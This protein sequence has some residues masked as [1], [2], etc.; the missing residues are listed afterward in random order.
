MHAQDSTSTRRS[1]HLFV[2]LLIVIAALGLGWGGYQLLNSQSSADDGKF[3]KRDRGS[4]DDQPVA[5]ALETV[6]Q[7]DLPI[8]LNGLGTVTP[9][10]TVTVHSRVDGEIVKLLFKEGQLVKTGDLLAEID[11]RLYDVQVQQAEGQLLRDQA[12]LSNA[13]LD[14][15]RYQKLSEQDS[16]ADQQTKTQAALVKQYKGTVAIDQA[17]L[18]NAKLQR[19]WANITAP[20]SGQIGLRQV[21]QGNI[22]HASDANGLFVLTQLQPISVL[23]TLP[24]DQVQAVVKRW[25]QQNG[26]PVTAYDRSGQ[27]ALAQG[28]LNAL[29]NQIDSTTGTL[30]LRAIFDNQEGSLFANQFVNIRMLLDTLQNA[31]TVS[32]AA[33]QHDNEGAYVYVVGDDNIA[34][35]RRV[36]LGPSTQDRIAVTNNLSAGEKVVIAGTDRLRTGKAVTIGQIDGNTLQTPNTPSELTPGD[37]NNTPRR[38]KH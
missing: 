21:D 24:E 32:T 3:G 28:Q 2:K 5:V 11:P 23:F 16:I 19:S 33:I 30:K 8:F 9:I 35:L 14:L 15:S 34:Q 27:N 4:R 20:I 7:A 18:N 22:I 12:L 29:D 37:D 17:Q 1:S 38:R 36:T 13:E 10:K 6:R 31:L 25:R 26:L